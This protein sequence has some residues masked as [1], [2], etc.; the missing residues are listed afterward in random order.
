[1]LA[2]AVLLGAVAVMLSQV[3]LNAQVSRQAA[4][5]DGQQ[6]RAPS[7]TIVVAAQPLRF[8]TRLT[9]EIIKEIEWPSGSL[10]EGVFATK[11]TLL[12]GDE[13]RVVLSAI[14][15]NEPL[16]AAKI[17]GP[18]QRASLSA[19]LSPGMKAITIRVNDIQGVA[20]FVLP[21][22]R[23]D[24][25]LT[26]NLGD[27]ESNK[28]FTDVILQDVRV[29]G[30]DQVADD[31]TEKPVVAKAVTFEV[32]T[33]DAQKLTLAQTVGV[34]SLALRNVSSQTAESASRRV[35]IGDL[36]RP[37]FTPVAAVV[38]KS[39]PPAPRP[40]P[41]AIVGVTRALERNEYSVVRERN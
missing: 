29:L 30:V 28:S 13:P 19:L 17:T 8:G 5:V 40:D 38:E 35:T 10:P 6:Q 32:T 33:E 11:A 36:S 14:E 25:M 34:L 23:V 26:R 27:A 41:F 31:R 15:V 1:M 22:D 3:W 37:A 20:G 2:I 7:R 24:V 18:G 39:A 16:L 9:P 4:V 12:S 21:G